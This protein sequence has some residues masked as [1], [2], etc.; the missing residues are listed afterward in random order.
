MKR[1]LIAATTLALAGT[2]TGCGGDDQPE[3]DATPST[4][5]TSSPTPTSDAGGPPADWESN[6][7][8]EELAAAEAAMARWDEYRPLLDQIHM[9]GKLT[10]GAKATLQ[11][12]DFWW[13][14]D[15]VTLGETYDKGGLRLVEGVEPLWS[16]AKSVRLNDDGTGEVVIVQCTNYEPLR[17]SRNGKPQEIEKPKHLITPLLITMTKPDGEHGWM[18]Q[19]SKLKDKSSCADE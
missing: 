12:Y 17:Y 10:P 18:H 3:S 2:L 13:Q 14:R 11:E 4:T 19:E 8:D 5:A 15:M 1:T 6:F 9:T 7:S 16:Y